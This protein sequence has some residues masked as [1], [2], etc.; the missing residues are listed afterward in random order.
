MIARLAPSLLPKARALSTPPVSGET[1]TMLSPLVVLLDMIQQYR[2]REEI[3]HRDVEEALD[4]T[5]MEIHRQ[6]P[7]RPRPGDQIGDQFGGDRRPGRHLP[8]LPPIAVIGNYGRNPVRGGSADGV[9]HDQ[10]FHQRDVDRRAGGLNDEDIHAAHI[11]VDLD[12]G[13]AVAEGRDM[14]FPEGYAQVLRD[15]LGEGH[16]RISGKY[17]DSFEHLDILQLINWLGREDSNLR[18]Q[19]PNSC[20]LPL[21]DA[22]IPNQDERCRIH[23]SSA[24]I[25]D[26]NP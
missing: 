11:F 22:P 3:V 6:D 23:G 19:D 4:L 16:I 5:G 2:G 20:V 21:D 14:G 25:R 15:F 12:A 9:D 24:K 8:V 7:V 13:F 1:I 10:Q 18:M 26:R 17:P